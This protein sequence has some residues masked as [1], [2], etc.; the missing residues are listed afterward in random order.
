MT[1]FTIESLKSK[2]KTF[3]DQK[4]SN[5]GEWPQSVFL[6][7]GNHKVRF[8]TDPENEIFDSYQTYG[9]FARGIRDPEHDTGV[10]EGFVNELKQ[11]Y[12]EHL[13]PR[14]K[15]SYGSK[16][17]FIAYVWL[18]ETDSPSENW[19]PGNLYVI[20][21]NNKFAESYVAFLGTLAKDAPEEIL[22]TLNPAN[23]GVILSITFKGGRDGSCSIGA[24]FPTKIGEPLDLKGKPY[25]PL[26][27]AY[28]RPG[29]NQEKYDALV[30]K[31][32]EDINKFSAIAGA[33]STAEPSSQAADVPSSVGQ[34]M[35]NQSASTAESKPAEAASTAT[36]DAVA[37]TTATDNSAST[38][39]EKP[40]ETPAATA[41]DDPWAKFKK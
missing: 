23:S 2:V 30:K 18:Y 27:L 6:P 11:L 21:A 32:K 8:I 41:A 10:P 25:I 4:S 33:N 12:T 31:Y 36:S 22:K 34:S 16:F 15:W 19:Q 13:Q 20:I 7:E 1:A 38:T 17:N 26:S 14:N 29:F 5:T 9:Y 24:S 39:E 40:T 37:S 3:Q 28:V 35:V